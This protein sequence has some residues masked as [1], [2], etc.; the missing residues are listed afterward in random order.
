[1]LKHGSESLIPNLGS[2]NSKL[3]IYIFEFYLVYGRLECDTSSVAG[4]LAIIFST[5][6]TPS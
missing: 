4:N 6:T 5:H 3:Y 2:E 1:M